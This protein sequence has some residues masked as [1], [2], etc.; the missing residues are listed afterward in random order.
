MPRITIIEPNKNPQPYSILTDRD[1]TTIGRSDSNDIVLDSTSASGNHCTIKRVKGGF[2]LEDNGST[3][4]ISIDD[5]RFQIID[6]ED[7]TE[8]IIGE[9]I[10]F[11]ISYQEEEL[12][13]L[14]EEGFESQQKMAFPN[15]RRIDQENIEAA[16]ATQPEVTQARIN[17]EQHENQKLSDAATGSQM[18]T[19]SKL[20]M[21]TGATAGALNITPANIAAPVTVAKKSTMPGM[22]LFIVLAVGC[23]L[24]GMTARHYKDHNLFLFD[25]QV[26]NK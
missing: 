20:V 6:L 17:A 3:N 1:V 4:G 13:L 26:E 10:T 16:Q 21:N 11:H 25:K 7:A 22:I 5:T 15:S 18:I 8:V 19:N 12:E 23:F 24:G 9:N 2:I 14:E